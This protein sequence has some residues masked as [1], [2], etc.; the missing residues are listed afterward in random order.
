MPSAGP[1]GRGAEDKAA[2]IRRKERRGRGASV[3]CSARKP[4]GAGDTVTEVKWDP[5][6]LKGPWILQLDHQKWTALVLLG[7]LKHRFL[8]PYAQMLFSQ[9]RFS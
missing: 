1:G 8:L 5:Q 6:E 3:R 2:L 7:L 9:S 4:Q